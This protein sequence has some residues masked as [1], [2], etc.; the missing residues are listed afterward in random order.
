LKKNTKFALDILLLLSGFVTLAS[1]TVVWFVLP[2]G[3]GLHGES[4]YCSGQ[5]VGGTGNVMDFLGFKRCNWITVHNWASVVLFIIIL[6]HIIFHWSW[7]LGTT[8]RI[9][10]TLQGPV[11]KVYEV[12]GS[13]VILLCLFIFDCLSGLVLWLV[14][15]RGAGDYT[16]MTQGSGRTFLG[17]QRNIWVDLHAWNAVMIVSIIIIHL[18]LNWNWVVGVSK[19]IILGSARSAN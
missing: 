15:P 13:V 11:K 19:R 18:I 16:H 3:I 2:R 1:S 4:A 17:L 5:G 10:R 6:V 9:F 8:R 12:Y 14:M 7:I